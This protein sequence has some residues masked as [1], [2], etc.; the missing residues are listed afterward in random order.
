MKPTLPPL[1]PLLA[2]FLL[3]GHG[4]PAQQTCAAAGCHDTL[5]KGASIH[6]ATDSC[7]G[8]HESV[9][10]PHPQKGKKTFKLAA[11]QPELCASCHE[12][13][14]KKAHVH[15]PVKDGC[16]TCHDPHASKEPKLLTAPLKDLCSSC[17]ADHVEFKVVHG[18]VSAG[19]CTACHTPH[20]SALKGLLLKQ[21]DALCM[22]CHLDVQ[23]GLKKKHVHAAVES[24]CTSC[25]NPHG[26]ANPKL[27]AEAGA[28]LCFQCHGEVAEKVQKGA[29][30]HAAV[31]SGKGCASCHSPHAA[32]QAKL[33]LSPEKELCLGCHKTVL[34]KNMTVLHGPIAD[35]QCT[36]CHDPHGGPNSRLLIR[37]FSSEPYLPYSDKEYELCFACHN[38][39]LLRFPDTSFATGFRDGDRNLHYLHVNNKLKGRSCQLCHAIHG[40]ENAALI[41]EKVTFGQWSL[42]LKFVKTDSGGSCAPGCHKP[43]AYARK[44]SGAFRSQTVKPA[45]PGK[46]DAAPPAGAVPAPAP[47]QAPLA[48][49]AAP[50]AKPTA[51]PGTQAAE[52]DPVAAPVPAPAAK[53]H[54]ALLLTPDWAGRPPVYV[55]HFS[56]H[57]DRET[58]VKEAQ[59]LGAALHAPAQAVEVD[60]G[61]KGVWYRVVVGAFT[62]ADAARAFHAELK[63]KKTPGMGFVY[64]MRGR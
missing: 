53:G 43:A 39:D 34:T 50:K 48:E 4:A 33:L 5:V 62:D 6:A 2:G 8:C 40:G 56:S 20:E 21:G 59:K 12:A 17:H 29:V 63:A 10:T 24:G 38:R 55:I 27:L 41:A 22:G 54:A 47:T 15:A 46:P 44:G 13:F 61:E 11:Q 18:P 3:A 28:A 23:E 45:P 60:L 30:V 58:A 19:A 9:A 37:R 57:S 32:D 64:E 16:T 25:H 7:D 51:T 49:P 26:S 31:T 42:P 36:P 35:G 1:A 14:G 52:A